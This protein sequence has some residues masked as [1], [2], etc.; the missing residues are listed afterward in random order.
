MKTWKY[1]SAFVIITLLAFSS[2][3]DELEP[4]DINSLE[5]DYF[6]L[7]IGDFVEYKV[8]SVIYNFQ[9]G[10]IDS[11]TSYIKEDVIERF[12]DS[13]EDTVYRIERTFRRNLTEDGA[14]LDEWAASRNLTQATRTEENLR[15]IKLVFPPKVGTRWD[16]N[17]HI[18]SNIE[19][20]VGGEFV[21]V[22]KNWDYQILEH[23]T[24]EEIGGFVFDDVITVQQADDE[25]ALELRYSIEKYAKGVGLVYKRMMILD[26]QC[27]AD[28]EDLSWEEK[29]EKGFILTQVIHDFN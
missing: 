17:I 10:S 28:C 11:F 1:I 2:C 25:N 19:I 16:G 21:E 27:I 22:Y 15:F 20:N 5:L 18:P 23:N 6:P 3:Q 9:N 12:F 8:D 7:E 4:L 29:A 14:I 26:T 13:N 24:E